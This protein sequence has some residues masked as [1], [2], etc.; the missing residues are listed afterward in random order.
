MILLTSNEAE[1]LVCLSSHT[2]FSSL[3]KKTDNYVL[4]C[5]VMQIMTS[6]KRTD[7]RKRSSC[8]RSTNWWRP[9]IFW[10]MM[11]SLN[12]SGAHLHVCL[13]PS[14]S[15]VTIG[16]GWIIKRGCWGRRNP[17]VHTNEENGVQHTGGGLQQHHSDKLERIPAGQNH[18][19]KYWTF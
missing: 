6:P 19:L 16:C 14:R 3:S 15:S 7:R 11:W 4:R 1:R 5:R 13:P 8:S 18:K 12:G 2:T 17:A 10:W 9:E